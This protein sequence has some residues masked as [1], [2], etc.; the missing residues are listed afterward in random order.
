VKKRRCVCVLA[1]N[2][3]F[4]IVLILGQETRACARTDFQRQDSIAPQYLTSHVKKIATAQRQGH[5]KHSRLPNLSP[6][7]PYRA[8]VAHTRIYDRFISGDTS[9]LTL[10]SS[11]KPAWIISPFVSYAPETHLQFGGIALYSFYV[12]HDSTTRVSA[13]SASVN[14]TLL[15]QYKFEMDPDV[16]TAHNVMHFTGTFI[17]QSIPLNYYGIGYKTLENDQ[18]VLASKQVFLDAEAELEVFKNFRIGLTGVYYSFNFNLPDNTDFL[19]TS[20][21]LYAL[22]GARSTFG[23]I[24]LIYDSRNYLNST[25]SGAYMRLNTAYAPQGV[26]T[27]NPLLNV[28]VQA[29]Y[30]IPVLPRNVLGLNAS[31]IGMY[32]RNVPFY[33]L[34]QLGGSSILRGYYSGRYR[35]KNA[36][37]IQ[38]EYRFRIIQ[39]LEL[40][41]FG[42]AGT[43]FGYDAYNSSEIKPNY[44]S[45]IRYFFDL[46]S[47]L[48]L[49]LDYG[50]GE[51][52]AGEARISGIYVQFGEAF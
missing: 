15:H 17:Y 40:A 47:R 3:L 7:I 30:F 46:A 38:A 29:S 16:W 32:G 24:S 50:V 20:P 5:K 22:K 39:R 45:G 31:A 1:K 48:S 27:I 42:G 9:A 21:S 26:S 14:Y 49:R 28:N 51:K 13:Q 34:P 18:Q 8:P 6:L 12:R 37:Q 25:T 44:G 19:Q 4:L 36:L 33:F 2:L 52:P 43:V 23:G 10:P 35:D 41:A 11:Q